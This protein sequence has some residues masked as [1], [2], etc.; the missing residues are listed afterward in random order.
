M[1]QTVDY[2]PNARVALSPPPLDLD[3]MNVTT[4]IKRLNSLANQNG[5]IFVGT[6]GD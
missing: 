5:G 1:G 3:V 2:S 6:H 4:D